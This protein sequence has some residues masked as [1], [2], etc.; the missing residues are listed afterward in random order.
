[1][2]N[3]TFN[4]LKRLLKSYSVKIPFFTK[5][6]SKK[7]CGIFFL[8]EMAAYLEESMK[9]LTGYDPIR[10]YD[11]DYYWTPFELKRFLNKRLEKIYLK[12][13]TASCVWE[14]LDIWTYKLKEHRERE[15]ATPT[16]MKDKYMLHITDGCR[17]SGMEVLIRR[18]WRM[19][20]S[21]VL[22]AALYIFPLVM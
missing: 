9:E 14:R 21:F 22:T 2:I 16:D 17:A 11:G 7:Q 1:M 3:V 18:W 12:T 6:W 15:H 13:K 4:N 20:I 5:M 19:N 8:D 10:D